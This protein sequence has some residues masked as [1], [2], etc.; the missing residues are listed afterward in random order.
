METRSE[1]CY[2]NVSTDQQQGIRLP[3]TFGFEYH[4]QESSIVL[5]LY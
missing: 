3:N 1:R 4:E 2:N 5:F